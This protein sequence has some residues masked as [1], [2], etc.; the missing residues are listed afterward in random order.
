MNGSSGVAWGAYAWVKLVCVTVQ[1][2]WCPWVMCVRS[3]LCATEPTF[4]LMNRLWKPEG[5]LRRERPDA[6]MDTDLV[7]G[8]K[9]VS[10]EYCSRHVSCEV[11]R[12]RH[13]LALAVLFAWTRVGLGELY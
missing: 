13:V 11:R 7:H 9:K 1:I 10:R 8:R 6:H 4:T 2:S 3:L 5:R 12:G